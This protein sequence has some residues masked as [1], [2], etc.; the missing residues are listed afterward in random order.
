MARRRVIRRPIGRAGIVRRIPPAVR[1][2]VYRALIELGQDTVKQ[3]KSKL[4]AG[5]HRRTG[6]LI[7]SVS[8]R[9]SKRYLMVWAGIPRVTSERNVEVRGDKRIVT[10]QKAKWLEFGTKKGQI[11]RS[12][13]IPINRD[14]RRKVPPEIIMQY[15]TAIDR[16]F[17]KLGHSTRLF[18]LRNRLTL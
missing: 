12:I 8:M 15:N 5:G 13:L 9:R 11:A 2:G 10:A 3:Y 4:R 17:A 6:K 18:A 7:R 14:L 16:I 1:D